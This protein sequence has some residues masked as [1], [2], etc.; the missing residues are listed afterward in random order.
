MTNSYTKAIIIAVSALSLILSGCKKKDDDKSYTFTPNTYSLDFEWGQTKEVGFT[1]KNIQ[2]Y[3]VPVAPE[4]WTCTRSGNTYT[5]T[6]PAQGDTATGTV[7]IS[8]T[9]KSG[10]TVKRNI[11]VSVRIAEE[12]TVAA[13][14]V[15]ISEPNKRFKFKALS[16]GNETAETLGA[17]TAA[18]RL[19]TTATNV[20]VNVSLEGDYLY[21][22]TGNSSELIEGNAVLAVTDKDEKILWSWHI[23]VTD[24]D[25]AEDP[26]IMGD[27]KVM[28]RNLGALANSNAS[29]EDAKRSYGLYYQ[30]GRKD[31]FIGPVTWDSTTSQ[32]IYGNSGGAV[33]HSF[34]ASAADTGTVEYAIANPSTFI[35]GRDE[36]FDWLYAARNNKLWSATSKTLYDPCPEGW[37]VAPPTI[38]AS[39]TTTGAASVDSE[40][41]NVVGDYEYGWTFANGDET[42]FY[43]AAGR[44]SFSSSLATVA[45]NFTN[46]VNNGEGVGYPVG[47]YWSALAPASDAISTVASSGASSLAF[48]N[49][50]VNPS[51]SELSETARAGGFPL[52]CIA[53]E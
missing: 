45:G 20:V 9:S 42:I 49:D 16:R 21:F 17:A 14:S 26:D 44:R 11:T 12:I 18:T 8:A 47:F 28:S 7:E 29:S 10:V 48:A 50:Y 23:W 39:L 33:T 36:T 37:R 3:A 19:W 46:V 5:I 34:K 30:W 53:E 41:F 51:G 22:A 38:W 24:Y 31:P 2:N 15:I 13:N 25:P 6:A 35:A 1:V 40:E 27:I 52:R 4:G 43:P 32:T